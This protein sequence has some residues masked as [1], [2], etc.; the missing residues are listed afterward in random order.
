M[1]SLLL[2]VA[3]V[4]SS[5]AALAQ[6]AELRHGSGPA[7]PGPQSSRQVLLERQELTS[8]LERMERL[9]KEAEERMDKKGNG[10]NK[11]R[12]ALEELEDLQRM[13]ARAPAAHGGYQPPQPLPPPRPVVQPIHESRLRQLTQAMARESFSREK[14]TV[15][16]EAARGDNFL[17]SQTKL[18]LEQFSFSNDKLEAVRILWPRVLDRD[19]AFQLYGAF[20]FSSDKEKLRKILEG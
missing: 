18:L 6:H 5:S 19:N 8:R 2:A 10:R 13:V 7:R 20:S 12:K 15:L 1:K 4:L 11:V 17:V 9:L 14:L 16:R 3:V